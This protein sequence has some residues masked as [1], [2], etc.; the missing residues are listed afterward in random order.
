MGSFHRTSFCEIHSCPDLTFM[1]ALGQALRF[2]APT[3]PTTRYFSAM[4]NTAAAA[5][6]S[7]A[8]PFS[9]PSRRYLLP[10]LAVAALSE[11]SAMSFLGTRV[12]FNKGSGESDATSPPPHRRR[13][14]SHKH[15]VCCVWTT[16]AT[17]YRC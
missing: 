12:E 5:S 16:T 1:L 14:H 6:T 17:L 7:A 8:S 9:G 3:T 2:S 10:L 15:T 11:L 4:P 13:C